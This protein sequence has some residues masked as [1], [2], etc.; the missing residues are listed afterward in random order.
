MNAQHLQG[1]V[2][3]VEHDWIIKKVDGE[4]VESYKNSTIEALHWISDTTL[5]GVI[6]SR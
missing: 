2:F 4:K 3:H 5:I 1:T 6:R